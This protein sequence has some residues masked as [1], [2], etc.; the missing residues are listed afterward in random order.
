MNHA[1]HVL[2]A[3]LYLIALVL[4]FGVVGLAVMAGVVAR[5][6]ARLAV[7]ALSVGTAC[8]AAFAAAGGTA[9]W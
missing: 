7:A 8:L 6:P 3:G 5:G 1:H 9:L 4:G 2:A